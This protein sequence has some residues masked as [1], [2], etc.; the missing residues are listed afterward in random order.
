MIVNIAITYYISIYNIHKL[1]INS[2]HQ[3]GKSIMIGFGGG[4]QL[5]FCCTREV[6]YSGHSAYVGID[7]ALKIIL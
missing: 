7:D 1:L 2:D 5:Q 3:E 6:S 4:N